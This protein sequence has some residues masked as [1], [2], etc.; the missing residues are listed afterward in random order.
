MQII[1]DTNLDMFFITENWQT[2]DDFIH[3]NML[4]LNG[5]Q[6]LSKLCV[7][8][9]GGGLAVICHNSITLIQMD[10]HCTKQFLQDLEL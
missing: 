5:Y 1:A 9:K 8:G 4:T 3:L 7:S 10:F 6:Y 2:P